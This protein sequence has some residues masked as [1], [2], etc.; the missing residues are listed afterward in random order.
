MAPD[1]S[2]TLSHFAPR[3]HF[4]PFNL[5]FVILFKLT[6]LNDSF[7]HVTIFATHFEFSVFYYVMICDLSLTIDKIEILLFRKLIRVTDFLF[8][9][10]LVKALPSLGIHVFDDY[11]RCYRLYDYSQQKY[12]SQVL[13]KT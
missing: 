1:F 7:D 11:I 13:E 6:H 2:Y 4:F 5:V 12:A 8:S 9:F 3:S 10:C